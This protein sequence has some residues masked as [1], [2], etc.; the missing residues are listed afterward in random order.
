M[1]NE[2]MVGSI[3]VLIVLVIAVCMIIKP[4]SFALG[5]NEYILFLIIGSIGFCGVFLIAATALTLEG[6]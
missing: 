4:D 1:R 6:R 2:T 5:S 3:L